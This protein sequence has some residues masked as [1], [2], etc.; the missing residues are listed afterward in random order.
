MTAYPQ[1]PP[2]TKPGKI[3]ALTILTLISGITNIVWALFATFMIVVGSM[4]IG[5][6][7]API[8]ILPLVLGIF[9]IIWAAKLLSTPPKPVQP[10][11]TIAIAEIAAVLSG[12]VISLAAGIMALVF[13]NDPEVVAYFNQ[14]NARRPPPRP[15]V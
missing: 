7:C 4:G 8:T 2:H 14:I 11:Q 6:V 15:T 10:S 3:T 13:Y 1:R 5:L 12:N 9:E